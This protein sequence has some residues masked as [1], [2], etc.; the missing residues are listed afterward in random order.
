MRKA[1]IFIIIAAIVVFGLHFM[2][3]V[4]PFIPVV[5]SSMEPTYDAGDLLVIGSKEASEIKL[6]RGM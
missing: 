1:L 3:T 2:K 4:F 6:S 5:G